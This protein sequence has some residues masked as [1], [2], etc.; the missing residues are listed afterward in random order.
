MIRQKERVFTLI[1]TVLS[2]MESG[3][4]T[5]N[6]VMEEKHGLM[7]QCMRET[8]CLERSMEEG[9]SNGQTDLFM[10]ENSTIIILRAKESTS[11]QM[12][13]LMTALGKTIKCMD[14]AYS[15]GLMEEGTKEITLKTKNKARGP[16]IGQ[17]RGSTLGTG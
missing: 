10:L 3:R 2:I 1:W 13:G 11:G 16:S 5:S 12:E 9:N 6:T 8:T 7:V 14:L 17:T 15:P 4:R